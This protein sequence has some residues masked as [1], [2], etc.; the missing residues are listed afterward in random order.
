MQLTLRP[1]LSE[2]LAAIAQFP[3]NPRELF[4]MFPNAQWP[5]TPEQLAAT[6][7]QRIDP[8]TLLIDGVPAGY[9]NLFHCEPGVSCE[10]GNI[11]V[12]PTRRGQGLGRAL[13]TYMIERAFTAYRVPRV[14][15]ACFGDDHAG[16]LLYNRL[17]CVPYGVEERRDP[18]G[19]RVALIRLRWLRNQV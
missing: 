17:G 6:A 1:L 7:E 19:E 15:I 11:I 14:E 16:L 9:A 5:L 12:D 8:T 4:W 3:R 18:Q 10:I 2:D 13:V